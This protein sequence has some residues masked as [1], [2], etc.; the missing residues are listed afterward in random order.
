MQSLRVNETELILRNTFPLDLF[1]LGGE[2]KSKYNERNPFLGL[3][4]ETSPDR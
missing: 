3:R 4:V 2:K 1:A